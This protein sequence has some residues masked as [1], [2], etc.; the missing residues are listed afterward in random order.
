MTAEHENAEGTGGRQTRASLLR[1][2]AG[3]LGAGLLAACGV[4]RDG[5]G[6]VAPSGTGAPVPIEFWYT[7]PDTHPT[8]K[9]R[10]DAL[11]VAE[12]A[13]G[14]AFTITYNEASGAGMAKVV[15]A[16]AAGTPPGFLIDYPYYAAQLFLKGAMV[17]VEQELKGVTAWGR[18]R[19]N[20][21]PAFLEGV[22]WMGNTVAIPFQISQ[23]AMMYA[24]DQLEKAGVA[25]PAPTWTWAAFEELSKRAARPPDVWGM[26]VGWRSSTWQLMAGSNGVSWLSKDQTKVSFTQPENLAGVEFLQK[27][28]YG[29]GLMP[30]GN[31]QKSAGELMIKG[32]T[33]FEPQ[34][35]YRVP[36]MRKAGV[37]RFGAA[38]WPRGP[39][40]PTPYHWGT[41]YSTIV[42][43]NPDPA[44]QRAATQAAVGALSDEAQAAHVM[45]D[46]GLPVTK[47]ARE[48]PAL[49]RF[50]AQE[51]VVKAF[52][53][54]FPYCDVW[55]AIPSGD[56]M[57][58][59]LDR[60]MLQ[61]YEQK[62]GIKDAMAAAERELQGVHDAYVAQT[63]ARK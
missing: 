23:Q 59:I 42:F 46:L 40:K 10:A 52:A 56:E 24:P 27:Y 39:Q 15:A 36:D 30:I 61:L 34:G 47:S 48:A 62:A 50:V 53:D 9:A 17:D 60:T 25:P 5:G 29:L 32:Q 37:T 3:A 28:T 18:A 44:K 51:P 55:P 6:A 41:L 22:R 1:G 35:P 63:Q 26:S 11:A 38:L 31:N 33:V 16:V 4:A 19:A 58:Q 7:L 54:M 49:Q 43:K 57:R 14:G 8:G 20:I 45:A 13:S 12:R 2:A 21:P